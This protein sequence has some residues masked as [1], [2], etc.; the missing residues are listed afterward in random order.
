[1]QIIDLEIQEELSDDSDNDST[2][3]QSNITQKNLQKIIFLFM[4]G[5]IVG[6]VVISLLI[7]QQVQDEEI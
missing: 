4:A 2:D 7:M 5:Q 3:S 1:M 6:T